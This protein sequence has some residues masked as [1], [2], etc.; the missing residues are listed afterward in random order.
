LIRGDLYAH[1]GDHERAE[2]AY[3]RGL[4]LV[5][6]LDLES[7]LL[8]ALAGILPPDSSERSELV[9]RAVKLDGSLVAHATSRLMDLQGSSPSP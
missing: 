5:E 3:R 4:E 9:G 8:C 2:A 6:E 7:R 1:C